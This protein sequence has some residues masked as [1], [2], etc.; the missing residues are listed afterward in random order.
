MFTK[1]Y[2][3]LCDGWYPIRAHCDS[4]LA[5][6]IKSKKLCVGDKIV[7][8]SSEIIGCPKDG[9]PP[10]EAPNELHLKL[11]VNSTRKARWFAK[12]GF[13]RPQKPLCVKLDTIKPNSNVGAVDVIVERIYPMLVRWEP[14]LLRSVISVVE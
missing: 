2:I 4:Y 12:L 6:F 14:W 10:L 5:G 13:V 7:I 8:Y 1:P 9:C 11:S 3:E